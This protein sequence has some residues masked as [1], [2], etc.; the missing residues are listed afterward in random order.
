MYTYFYKV[1]LFL[2]LLLLVFDPRTDQPASSSVHVCQCG[3]HIHAYTVE[4]REGGREREG[5]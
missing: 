4:R 1:N 3:P 2:L 5:G